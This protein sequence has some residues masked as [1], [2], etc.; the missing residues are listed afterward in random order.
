MRSPDQA[1]PA[2]IVLLS[3]SAVAHASDWPQFRGPARDGKSPEVNLLKEWPK[4]G[5]RLLWTVTGLGEG[6]SS[7]AVHSG[8]V[9]T[10]GMEKK[11]ERLFAIDADG[12]EMWRKEYGGA[13][14]RS[15]PAARTTPTIDGEGLYV[16]SG[17][18]EVVCLNRAS[19]DIVW[20]VDGLATFGGKTGNWGTAECP[21]VDETKVYYTPCGPKTTVVALDKRTG[22][23]V[24]ASE[25]LNDQSAYVSPV[26]VN[27][28]GRD[29]LVTITARHIIGV[30]AKAGNILWKY[31]YAKNHPTASENRL[32]INAVSPLYHDG[33][34][35]ATSGYDHVGV[36]FQLS[37]DGTKADP[38]WITE[39][40]DCHH[41]GVVFIDGRIH[42][43]NWHSNTRGNWICL[44]WD[45]GKV[46]YD[47]SWQGNK[48]PVIFAEGMLYCW[49]EDTGHVALVKASATKFDPVSSFQVTVG[50]GK[51]WAHP[52]ISEGRLYLRHGEYL[53]A[54]D[55]QAR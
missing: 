34:V 13:W 32:M 30:D 16:I 15:Y 52:S 53:M 55:I 45:T 49:D 28:N 44:D 5:P 35:F 27:H 24:W 38:L 50:E 47:Q 26:L 21:L 42:G 46:L 54:Y 11:R 37:S 36:M 18:G 25:S 20:K 8:H 31:A 7:A 51:F 1:C 12:R 23:T 9:Y 14:S 29:L 6:W 4:E 33:R 19:G 41:G 2:L 3:V 22:E 48:G 43:S 39:T 40:L 10:T 17:A